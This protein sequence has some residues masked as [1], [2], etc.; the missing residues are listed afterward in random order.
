M[1][2]L[3]HVLVAFGSISLATYVVFRPSRHLLY[4]EYVSTAATIATGVGLVIIEPAHM[5]HAC[6]AGL[7]YLAT[8]SIMTTVAHLRL[9]ALRRAEK[10][11]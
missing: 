9:A 3:L 2:V 5:L 4:L 11:Q 10:I 6:L 8:A 1:M 7:V